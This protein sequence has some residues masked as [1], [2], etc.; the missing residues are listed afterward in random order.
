M[1]SV[2]RG[3]SPRNVCQPIVHYRRL[4]EMGD[5]GNS[6]GTIS[7]FVVVEYCDSLIANLACVAGNGVRTITLAIMLVE[8]D[9]TDP[10]RVAAAGVVDVGV[11]AGGRPFLDAALSLLRVRLGKACAAAFALDDTFALTGGA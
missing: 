1:E 10:V 6:A 4:A 2:E 3:S 5:P 8:A 9:R 11:V 7:P